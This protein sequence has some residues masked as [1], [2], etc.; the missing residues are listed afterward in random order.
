MS[1]AMK[2]PYSLIDLTHTIDETIPTWEDGCGFQHNIKLDYEACTSE[3]KFKVGQFKM[4]AGIG[5]HLDVPAHCIPGGMTIEQIPLS[6][7]VAPCIV[8]DVSADAHESYHISTDDIKNFEKQFF[9]ISPGTFV[10]FKTGWE[11]FWLDSEKYRNHYR[12]PSVSKDT[13]LMLLEKEVCGLGIDTLSPDRPEDGYP[14]HQLWLQAGKFIVE[15]AAKERGRNNFPNWCHILNSD[16]SHFLILKEKY[17]H[18][19]SM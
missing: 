6:R 5:T 8:V 19:C 1:D 9:P 4:P 7:L 17:A 12:F 16:L 11:R 2:F 3:V 15:N 14:V 13:A 18:S 10:M